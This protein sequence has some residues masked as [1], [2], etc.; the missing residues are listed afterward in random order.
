MIQYDPK[1]IFEQRSDK[2]GVCVV[3][4]IDI[5]LLAGTANQQ[6]LAAVTGKSI[7]ILSG[8][9]HSTGGVGTLT[10][11]NGSGGT[12]L[13]SKYLPAVT[14]NRDPNVQLL[15]RWW[16]IM[17]T[18][19]GTGLFVTTTGADPIIVSLNYIEVV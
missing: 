11:L 5:T 8:S 1:G 18:T 10:F 12:R 13:Y 4:D 16:G 15:P 19:N 3:K 14:G 2:G 6:I 17:R 7:V 9:I